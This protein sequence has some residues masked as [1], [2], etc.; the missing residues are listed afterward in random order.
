MRYQIRTA[1]AAAEDAKTNS[2]QLPQL[3]LTVTFIVLPFQ[4]SEAIPAERNSRPA[5]HLRST[6]APGDISSLPSPRFIKRLE[7]QR[8]TSGG[9]KRRSP[10]GE[11]SCCWFDLFRS[12]LGAL[13]SIECSR[14]RLNLVNFSVSSIIYVLSFVL[15]L[16]I[17]NLSRTYI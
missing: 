10:T 17:T 13:F 12:L 7:D 8:E 16:F 11:V 6:R 3:G 2:N 4:R 1:E 14:Q 9:V 15:L 5:F